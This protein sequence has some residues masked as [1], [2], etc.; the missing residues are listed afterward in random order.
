MLE[1]IL[2]MSCRCPTIAIIPDLTVM[3]VT[4]FPDFISNNFCFW[5]ETLVYTMLREELGQVIHLTLCTGE[6]WMEIVCGTHWQ[7][8]AKNSPDFHSWELREKRRW[9]KNK[10]FSTSRD[11]FEEMPSLFLW[12]LDPTWNDW[13]ELHL[14]LIPKLWLKGQ[15]QINIIGKLVIMPINPT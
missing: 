1:K 2:G 8:Q 5:S 12:R 14:T 7:H 11:Y 4:T 3:I 6:Q 15:N 13:R 9:R 10:I